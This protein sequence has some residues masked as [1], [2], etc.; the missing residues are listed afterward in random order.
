MSLEPITKIVVHPKPEKKPDQ[1]RIF[2]RFSVKSWPVLSADTD[3]FPSGPRRP[4]PFLNFLHLILFRNR[5]SLGVE[6]ARDTGESETE[7]MWLLT[8][9]R[10]QRRQTRI[11]N[12]SSDDLQHLPVE[13]RRHRSLTL[14]LIKSDAWKTRSPRTQV[15]T[16]L[17]TQFAEGAQAGT[18][19]LTSAKRSTPETQ[20]GGESELEESYLESML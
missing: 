8:Q 13:D 18:K 1:Q 6:V 20:P 2:I 10:R 19:F 12:Q 3:V 15:S 5:D 4:S 9:S 16:K 11:V 7:V 14:K 17:E